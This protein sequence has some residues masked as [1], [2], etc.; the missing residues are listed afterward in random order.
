MKRIF[1]IGVGRSGTSLVQSMLNS[2]PAIA[3]FPE[4]QFLRKY[5][6]RRHR[7][8]NTSHFL[9][10]LNN[11]P[12]YNR[13][14]FTCT[15]EFASP[16]EYYDKLSAT[17]LERQEK[18]IIGDKDPRN[19]E[20]VDNLFSLFPS[21]T[22]IHVIRD[23]RDVVLSRTKAQWSRRWPFF[24]HVFIYETQILRGLEM[25]SSLPTRSIIEIRYEELLTRPQKVL[26]SI[27][28]SLRIPYDDAML[29]FQKSASELMHPAERQWKKE[30]LQPLITD[31]TAKW[32]RSMTAFQVALIET[33]CEQS[34]IRNNYKIHKPKV[35]PLQQVSIWTLNRLFKVFRVFYP[36]RLKTL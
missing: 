4:T 2:H 28:Q 36:L 26:S 27:T 25:S 15:G 11:D 35:T 14:G 19:I 24:L 22:I 12:E 18:S 21:S 13:I 17:F 6:W 16:E 20:F 32:V 34:M 9:D 7:W 23:P 10:T 29:S 5:I 8:K 3:F 30:T 33:I 31:N 1:I